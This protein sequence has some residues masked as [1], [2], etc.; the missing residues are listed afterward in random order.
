MSSFAASTSSTTVPVSSIGF[1]SNFDSGNGKLISIDR[2]E[3]EKSMNAFIEI[4]DDVS[5]ELEKISFKQWFHFRFTNVR[6]I[7]C[8]FTI[9]NAGKCAFQVAFNGYNVCASYD[10]ENW[11]RIPTTYDEASGTMRW[12]VTPK[13]PQIYF[14]Y[15]PPYS[16]EKH[17]DLIAWCSNA[18]A[19][20][21]TIGS[22]LRCADI[23]MITYGTGPRKVW[24]IA[25]Q[26]PGESQGEWFMD[27][28]LRRLLNPKDSVARHALQDA[29][30]YVVPNINP[31]GSTMGHLRTNASGA[32]LN[33]EWT[34]TGDYKAPTLKNSP[35]VYHL[36]ENTDRLGCDLFLDVH[37]DEELPY[38]FVSGM[39]GCAVWGPRLEGLQKRFGDELMK[40]DPNYQVTHGYE[41]DPP[42]GANYALCSNQ[43]AQRYD[44]LSLTLEMPFKD[45]MDCRGKEVTFLDQEAANFGRSMLD[46]IKAV[47]PLL[48]A[49]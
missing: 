3:D 30:F 6:D 34:S 4:A 18:G 47:L 25:R 29:T 44:C 46:A 37:G 13:S 28:F 17:L 26:H 31:D 19:S 49:N 7:A 8:N 2:S 12:S 10:R 24:L 38:N 48:R 32:N 43:M 27:G 41:L 20:V 36:L 15:F 33:R 9:A 22:S 1:S 5:S 23:D 21:T 11:F 16:R 39:E 40:A 45:V 42:L 35:E 14:A